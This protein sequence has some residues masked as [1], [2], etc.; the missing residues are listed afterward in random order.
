VST[1]SRCKTDFA[2]NTY[3]LAIWQTRASAIELYL[4]DIKIRLEDL[5]CVTPGREICD[6]IRLVRDRIPEFDALGH[7]SLPDAGIGKIARV[8]TTGRRV[9]VS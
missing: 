2:R 6:G 5:G 7:L 1:I 4:A 9:V 8:E 3:K